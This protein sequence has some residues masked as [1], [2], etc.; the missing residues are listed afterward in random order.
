MWR[1]TIG[2]DQRLTSV[3]G[4]SIFEALLRGN[5]PNVISAI[6]KSL[7]A[8]TPTV[9]TG[10]RSRA[11]LQHSSWKRDLSLVKYVGHNLTVIVFLITNLDTTHTPQTKRRYVY[12]LHRYQIPVQLIVIKLSS[13]SPSNCPTRRRQTVQLITLPSL[14]SSNCPNCRR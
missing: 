8:T 6:V 9:T 12:G 3:C 5:I 13:L 10:S 2:A 7:C 1:A 11:A 4:A 14:S